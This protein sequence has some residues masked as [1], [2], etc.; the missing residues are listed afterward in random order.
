MNSTDGRKMIKVEMKNDI[1][2]KTAD[3]YTQN[4]INFTNFFLKKKREK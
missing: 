2:V 3:D 4:Q 1:I